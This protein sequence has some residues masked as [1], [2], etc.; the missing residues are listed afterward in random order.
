M[1]HASIKRNKTGS[2]VRLGYAFKYLM[3]LDLYFG[4]I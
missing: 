1:S 4:V 3:E 2:Q